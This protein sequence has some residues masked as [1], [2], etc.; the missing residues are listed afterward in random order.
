MPYDY[1][2]CVTYGNLRSTL[3]KDGRT[4]APNDLWIAACAVRHSIPLVSNNRR[5]FENIPGLVL[6]SEARVVGE[7]E[8]QGGLFTEQASSSSEPQ[9]P[10]SRSG[11][12]SEG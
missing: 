1:E 7:I 5:H 6:I 4:V 2:L 9:L 10:S 3:A 12:A 8:G 11:G